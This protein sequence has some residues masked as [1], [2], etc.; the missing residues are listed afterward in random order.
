AAKA[1]LPPD[2]SF[3]P[4]DWA[5]LS[6][7]WHPVARSDEVTDRPFATR[8][9]D[10]DLVLY[11]TADGVTAA[12]DVCPHRGGKLSLGIVRDGKL[13]CGFHGLHFDACGKCVHIPSLP[14]GAPISER[15]KLETWQCQERYGF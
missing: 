15:F 12:R 13:V 14:P 8:L 9:L 10:V 2:C 7:F 1:V 4:S 11:R 3:N 6:R 5:I